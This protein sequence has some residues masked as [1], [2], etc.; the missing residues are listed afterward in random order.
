MTAIS[1]LASVAT[2]AVSLSQL[3][4]IT[5][6]RRAQRTRS[7]VPILQFQVSLLS[8]VLWTKYGLI[9]KDDTVLLVNILGTLISIYVL[10]CFWWY[11]INARYVETRS[12]VTLVC[13]LLM[14]AYVDHSSDPWAEDAFG[15]ACCL[16]T[17][18]FLGSP[19]SQIGN[20]IHLQDASVLLPSVALLAF[21]NNLLWSLYGH[22]HNDAFMLFPNAIGSVL[23]A[24]QLGLIAY[25]GRAAANLPLTATIKPDDGDG[26]E[27]V[28]M[29]EIST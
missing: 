24:V 6:L 26:V 11:S 2:I 21:F 12:L 17:L 5:V 7:N 1:V 29:T 20:V 3:S 9:R 16:V 10:L 18:L 23:C 15:L 4:I 8:S 19:L 13:A 14:I 22:L 25:Y 27:S 28:P